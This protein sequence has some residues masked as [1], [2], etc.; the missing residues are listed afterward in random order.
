MRAL[1]RLTPPDFEHVEKYPLTAEDLAAIVEPRAGA[2]GINWYTSFDNPV[3]GSDGRYRIKI[4]GT[5]RGGHCICAEPVP[6]PEQDTYAYHVFYNQGETPACT[7]FGTS[8]VI[9][10]TKRVTLNAFWLYDDARRIDG[11]YPSGE[12][13]YVRSAFAAAKKWG[14]HREGGEVCKPEP[15]HMGDPGVQISSYKWITSAEQLRELLGYSPSVVELPLLN[16]WGTDYPETVYIDL[17]DVDTLL[18][19]EGEAGTVIF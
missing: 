13:S 7:G 4:S 18:K 8:R 17:D 11:D 10:L 9:T 1:G 15:W 3:K 16:S 5:V 6:T 2:L 12:G 14:A 19:Q